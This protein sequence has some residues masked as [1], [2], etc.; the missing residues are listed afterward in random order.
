[1]LIKLI[2]HCDA[3]VL[4]SFGFFKLMYDGRT[5]AARDSACCGDA[6]D[7]EAVL[8][9]DLKPR[10]ARVFKVAHN[11]SREGTPPNIVDTAGYIPGRLRLWLCVASSNVE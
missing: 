1:M 8:R 7:W 2:K 5:P 6:P 4:F 11:V 10:R 3:V 9:L